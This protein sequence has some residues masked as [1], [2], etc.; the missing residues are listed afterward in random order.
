MTYLN[1]CT[2]IGNLCSDHDLKIIKTENGEERGAI[3]NNALGISRFYRNSK[4]EK[5]ENTDFVNF[6]AFNGA[7]K[8]IEKN[9][10][11]GDSILLMGEMRLEKWESDDGQKRSMLK[12]HVNEF[13][14]MPNK[15]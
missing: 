1:T 13:K 11:K 6:S 8:T 14:F 2:F 5:V 3:L 10:K 7:A 15:N 9:T 4:G 12:L